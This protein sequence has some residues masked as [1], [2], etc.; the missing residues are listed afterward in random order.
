VFRRNPRSGK[1]AQ[2]PGSRGCLGGADASA[3]GC[4]AAGPLFDVADIDVSPDGRHVYVATDYW[5]GRRYEASFLTVYARNAR[6]G[7]LRALRPGTQCRD[8][9]G[10]PP[11]DAYRIA[12]SPNG[13]NVYAAEDIV[14]AYSR[15]PRTG[16]LRELPTPLGCIGDLK[17]IRREYR[18][19]TECRLGRALEEPWEIAVSADGRSVY[20]ATAHAI[21]VLRRDRDTGALTQP[22]GRQGCIAVGGRAGCARGRVMDPASLRISRGGGRLYA[23]SADPDSIAVMARNGDTG[24]L[25]QLA[26][27]AGCISRVHRRGCASPRGFT[28][29]SAF[30]LSPHGRN[31]YVVGF[32]GR[33]SS[34]S[35][36]RRVPGGGLAQLAGIRGCLTESARDGCASI[37]GLSDPTAVATIGGGLDLIVAGTGLRPFRRAVSLSLAGWQGPGR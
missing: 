28:Q 19:R 32:T 20:V 12:L 23:L 16:R 13:R 25:R 34:I 15:D 5:S 2:L 18:S 10:R 31:L 37:P 9:S 7:A 6:T 21:A 27:R 33:R 26:G 36:F 22:P 1:L 4:S 24:A 35:V 8:A 17:G 3:Y 11:C 29:P 30:E 14:R